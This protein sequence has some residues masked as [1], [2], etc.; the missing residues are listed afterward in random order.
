M[1]FAILLAVSVA[2][3]VFGI[4]HTVVKPPA[5]AAAAPV[6]I[7][8]SCLPLLGSLKWTWMSISPGEMM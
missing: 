5:A 6:A 4:V 7:V 2:G 8:S 3:V 1:A